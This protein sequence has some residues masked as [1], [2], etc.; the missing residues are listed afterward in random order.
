[1]TNNFRRH[2]WMCSIPTSRAVDT[3]VPVDD[4]TSTS[5]RQGSPSTSMSSD[6]STPAR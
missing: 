1:M 6:A 5:R 4:L 2:F 3:V